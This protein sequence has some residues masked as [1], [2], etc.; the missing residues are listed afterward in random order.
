MKKTYT[1]P[2]IEVTAYDVENV[3]TADVSA[4]FSTDGADGTT[5]VDYVKTVDYTDIFG[6]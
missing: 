2:E 4:L 5:L 3:V 1:R 6:A